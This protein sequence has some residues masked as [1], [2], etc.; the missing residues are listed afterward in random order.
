MIF[1][2]KTSLKDQ[3]SNFNSFKMVDDLR[4]VIN[5]IEN[6]FNKN[7]DFGVQIGI[8]IHMTYMFENAI[9]NGERKKHKKLNNFIK[10]NEK[11]FSIVNQELRSLEGDYSVEITDDEKAYITEMFL[12]N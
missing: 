1:N 10:N 12:Y 8:I 11:L 9:E 3:F 6:K 5:N 4:T 7:L 2:I